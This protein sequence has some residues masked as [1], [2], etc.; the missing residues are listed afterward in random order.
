MH[1]K[2][3]FAIMSGSGA[4]EGTGSFRTVMQVDSNSC[5]SLFA[6]RDTGGPPSFCKSGKMD[7]SMSNSPSWLLFSLV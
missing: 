5:S 2:W 4:I 6:A 3:T 1:S 7:K